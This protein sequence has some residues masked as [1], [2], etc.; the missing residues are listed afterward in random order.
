MKTSCE[1]YADNDEKGGLELELGRILMRIHRKW[2]QSGDDEENR[3]EES[4]PLEEMETVILRSHAETVQQ[5]SPVED[6]LTE[7]VILSPVAVGEKAAAVEWPLDD[8][9]PETVIIAPDSEENLDETILLPPK[10]ER[11]KRRGNY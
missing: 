4:L 9:V 11:L 6:E 7:T 10:R 3:P 1:T 2:Q 8:A 5:E